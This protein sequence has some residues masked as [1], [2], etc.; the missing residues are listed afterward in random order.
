MT[1]RPLEL[2]DWPQEVCQFAMTEW[3]AN[4]QSP[5]DKKA[6]QLQLF[7]HCH[8]KSPVEL[9][10]QL[11]LHGSIQD[12]LAFHVH[13]IENVPMHQ[14]LGL[15]VRFQNIQHIEVVEDLSADET[16]MLKVADLPSQIVS[17][18]I[19][20]LWEG[21]MNLSAPRLVELTVD[22]TN[23]ENQTITH[24]PDT[25]C[26]LHLTEAMI[27][28]SQLPR[29]LQHLT[30][31]MQT[32]EGPLDWE[33]LPAGLLSLT[34]SLVYPVGFRVP[35][36]VW[37]RLQSLTTLD[38]VQHNNSGPIEGAIMCSDLPPALLKW[39]NVL[40]C[41][42]EGT[43]HLPRL[44][45]EVSFLETDKSIEHGTTML[46]VGS[47][48]PTLVKLGLGNQFHGNLNTHDLLPLG[49]THLSCGT[50]SPREIPVLSHLLSLECDTNSGLE[51]MC[52]PDTLTSLKLHTGPTRKV[53]TWSPAIL[54]ATLKNLHCKGVNLM[55]TDVCIMERLTL[56]YMSIHIVCASVQEAVQQLHRLPIV[57]HLYLVMSIDKL[58]QY[59]DPTT[60][61]DLIKALPA[62]VMFLELCILD[63][64][65]LLQHQGQECA[66][67]WPPQLHSLSLQCRI[68]HLPTPSMFPTTLYSLKFPTGV[69][70][71]AWHCE[72][73]V[74]SSLWQHMLLLKAIPP[75]VVQLEIRCQDIP[76]SVFQQS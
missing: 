2:N 37:Q 17:L 23:S 41:H 18:H 68:S 46:N 48:P 15:S 66:S 50:L 1:A 70:D 71:E 29:G 52:I 33:H 6:L 25:L 53:Y 30:M 49:L 20:E 28:F 55:L 16:P 45:Q 3:R 13:W 26:R 61:T 64:D 74:E 76:T 35:A 47:L 24:L 27:S 19:Y 34:L 40:L 39:H 51:N 22:L 58:F 62:S 21:H 42:E 60:Y 7:A 73:N 67:S 56:D 43:I 9:Q 63:S 8:W 57:R 31:T 59:T 32:E 11:D 12:E 65:H 10:N 5:T 54:P 44:L 75:Q 69:L 14:L 38:Y 4:A 72:Y 36:K